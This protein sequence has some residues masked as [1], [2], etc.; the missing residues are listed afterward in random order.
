[1]LDNNLYNL[2]AQLVEEHKSL[3]RIK[4][5]YITDAKK[6]KECQQFWKRLEDDKECHIQDLLCLIQNHLPMDMSK[7]KYYSYAKGEKK[8]RALKKTR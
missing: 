6:C 7:K 1:M 2:M 5:M 4:C 3:Y 8:A